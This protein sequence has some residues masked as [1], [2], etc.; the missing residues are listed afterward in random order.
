M[1]EN[2]IREAFNKDLEIES[3]SIYAIP[4]HQLPRVSQRAIREIVKD[5]YTQKIYELT[6]D[7]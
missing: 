3:M 1:Q 4:Y 7:D 5:Y 6:E 2:N